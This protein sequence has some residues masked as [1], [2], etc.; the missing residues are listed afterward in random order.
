MPTP[1]PDNTPSTPSPDSPESLTRPYPPEECRLGAGWTAYPT[2]ACGLWWYP[3]VEAS[4][5][6]SP[7]DAPPTV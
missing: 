6:E 4:A 3:K 2:H 5:H 1:E 7:T